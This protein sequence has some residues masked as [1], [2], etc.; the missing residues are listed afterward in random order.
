MPACRPTIPLVVF[1]HG[2]TAS[3]PVYE[4]LLR[5]WAAAGY[6]IAA[7]TFPLSSTGAPGDVKLFDYVNQPADVSFV[8]D[9]ML[10]RNRTEGDP[11][12]RRIARR[13]IA[14]GGHSLGAITTFGVAYNSC[15]Q[16]RRIDAA[17]PFSGITLPFPDGAFFTD[18]V[19]PAAA[20]L[21]VHGDQ[22][23]TVPYVG[24]TR[25]YAQASAPKYLETLVGGPHTPFRPPWLGPV[26]ASV[27]DF[28]DRY[29]KG[30]PGAGA[31]LDRDAQVEGVSVLES[32]PR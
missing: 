7:P 31:A 4:R 29:L 24:S 20:L 27:T 18:L 23:G 2:L 15:C 32:Q 30:E 25:A 16:D 19:Y 3:G 11:L 6:V 10:E 28:L 22:D 1:A 26:V 12:Y 8:I 5:V 13:H 17:I 9:E 21:L 14:A